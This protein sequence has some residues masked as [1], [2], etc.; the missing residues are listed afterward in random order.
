MLM[1]EAS[2]LLRTSSLSIQQI[3]DRLH[4][5]NTPS[6]SKFFLKKGVFPASIINENKHVGEKSIEKTEREFE[7]YYDREMR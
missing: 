3:A 2:F 6:L 5:A 7:I 1:I 4:F